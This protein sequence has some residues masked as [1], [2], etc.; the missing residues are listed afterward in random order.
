V[1]NPLRKMFNVWVTKA[2]KN[3]YWT[4]SI[5]FF[6]LQIL[7]QSVA[8]SPMNSTHTGKWSLIAAA[9]R[10]RTAGI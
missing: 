3:G 2:I 7:L 6:I 5:A 1:S 9:A 8:L 4:A 10:L